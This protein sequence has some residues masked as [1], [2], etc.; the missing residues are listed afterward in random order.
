ML[1]KLTSFRKKKETNESLLGI[2]DKTEEKAE[3]VVPG[4]GEKEQKVDK[5]PKVQ[6]KE[7]K[8]N[9]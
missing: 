9:P 2:E 7:K 6:G 5:K 8:S 1:R 3:P 4:V